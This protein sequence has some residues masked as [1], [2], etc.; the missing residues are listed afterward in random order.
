MDEKLRQVINKVVSLA[1][2]NAEFNVELR[3]A[4]GIAPS[5][6]SVS[7]NDDRVKHIE[8]YLGLDY[9]VD[10]QPS[11]IDYSFIKE[12]DIR[13]QLISD[14]R[15]MMRFRYG[16]RYHEIKFDE[17]CRYT[18]FQAE[19]LLNYFYDKKNDGDI[20]K[21]IDHI[22]TYNPQAKIQN[23]ESLSAISFAVK[24]WALRNQFDVYVPI[25]IWDK[26]REARN[27]LSHRS[28]GE[29]K[30]EIENY[31]KQLIKW[32]FPMEKSGYINSKKLETNISLQY[33]FESKIKGSSIYKRYCFLVWFN[34]QPYGSIFNALIALV[35]LIKKILS[36]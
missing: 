2:Q 23:V 17:Y 4:L 14:N 34:T 13:A 35:N 5:A 36:V 8:K 28:L 7:I 10:N 30:V 24:L 11:L 9:Y 15:E 20:H 31:Y 26:V 6:T 33:I 25:S 16:T 29:F 18:L 21:I 12:N 1:K 27:M 3:K 32:G 19:M 22:L